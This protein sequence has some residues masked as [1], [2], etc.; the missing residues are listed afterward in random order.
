MGV[1]SVP[2]TIG[3]DE[4]RIAK[5]IEGNIESMVLEKITNEVKR[6][7]YGRRYYNSRDFDENDLSPV[8]EMVRE[9]IDGILEKH[10]QEIIDGAITK[11]ADR[12][13]RKKVVKTRA[14]EITDG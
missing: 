3:V 14:E 8:V 1:Y 4:H 11:L 13:S 6:T 2:V 12:L 9:A 7:I 5:E 10:E